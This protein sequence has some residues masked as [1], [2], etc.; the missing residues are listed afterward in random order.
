MYQDTFV[1]NFISRKTSSMTRIMT[2]VLIGMTVLTGLGML[3]SLSI[4]LLIPFLMFLGFSYYYSLQTVLDFDY[5][6]TNGTFEIARIRFKRKRKVL[7][8]INVREEL[9]VVAPSRTEPVM[10]YLGKKMTTYDCTSHEEGVRY[11]TMIARLKS[12]DGQEVKVL[13]EPD[14]AMLTAMERIVPRE[15]HREA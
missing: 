1:E 9:V 11:Y 7:L 6:F 8:S 4:Y 3:F 2:G 5:S 12:H 15:I 10:P 14:D 13:F